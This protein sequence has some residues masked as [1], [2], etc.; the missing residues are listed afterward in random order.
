MSQ[1]LLRR[2]WKCPRNL[3][4][5]PRT[6][7]AE[8]GCFFIWDIPLF[9]NLLLVNIFCTHSSLD[10]FSCCSRFLVLFSWLSRNPFLSQHLKRRCGFQKRY[11]K[12]FS[13]SD[14]TKD[15]LSTYN[16]LQSISFFSLGSHSLHLFPILF[17]ICHIKG[18]QEPYRYQNAH[19]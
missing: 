12:A 15:Q 17:L 1:F 14:E 6:E 19:F 3:M 10:R 13:V 5:I 4:I 16:P 18:L 8:T 2:H 7:K 9:Q 11:I